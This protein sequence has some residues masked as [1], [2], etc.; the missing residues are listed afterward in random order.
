[1]KTL[2]ITADRDYSSL[3]DMRTNLA[4]CRFDPTRKMGFD[5][6]TE[7]LPFLELGD[8]HIFIRQIRIV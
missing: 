5:Y 3:V 1:M 2:T 8:S 7:I 6:E 4:I